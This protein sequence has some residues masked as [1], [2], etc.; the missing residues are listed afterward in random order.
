MIIVAIVRLITV[1]IYLKSSNQA[2]AQSVAM[3]QVEAP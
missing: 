2:N 3:V 1:A